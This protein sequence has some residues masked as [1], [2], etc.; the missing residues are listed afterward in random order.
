[1]QSNFS[2]TPLLGVRH[3]LHIILVIAKIYTVQLEIGWD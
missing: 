1:M 2:D 3:M